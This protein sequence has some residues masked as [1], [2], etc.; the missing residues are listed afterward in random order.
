MSA[1]RALITGASGGIG[2]AFA[3][4]LAQRGIAVVLVARDRERLDDLARR[5]RSQCG[6]AVEV[7]PADLSDA[8]QRRAVETRASGGID[9]LVNVAGVASVGRFAELAAEREAAQ[10]ALNLLAPMR[11]T[12]AALP[13]M[14]AQRRGAVIIVS[15]IA[16]FV[17]ARFA[18]TYAASKAALNSFGESLHEELRGSG[19]QVQVLC[20]GFTR[21]AFVD[22]AGADG[23]A[24]PSFAWMTPDA[25]VEAS[26]ASLR[27]RRVICVPGLR[28]RLL[29]ALLSGLPRRWARRL[30]GAGAKQG[31]AA[32]AI[33][34]PDE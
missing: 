6:A 34:R 33:R 15:S 24:I 28:N 27:R 23:G 12:R 4:A 3:F 29:T 1:G 18:A 26:L 2:A 31:W 8:A 19:V 14:I 7:L 11:L 17:P 9:L 20:P 30:T 13:A 25:V 5:L 16:A 21:T 10:I 32:Q 22:R